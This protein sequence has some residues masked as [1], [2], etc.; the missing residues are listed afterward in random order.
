MK[1]RRKKHFVDSAVQG[2]L[3]RRIILHWLIF[4]GLA[5]LM[6]PLWQ[7]WASGNIFSPFSTLVAESWKN[8]APV[9]LALIALLPL[10]IW[11]TVTLTHRFAGPMRRF[12]GSIKSLAAGDKVDPIRLRKGDFWMEFAEDFN[13]LL[14]RL[15][16]ERRPGEE[17]DQEL[18]AC[19]ASTA[20]EPLDG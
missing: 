12:H 4:L 6:L 8:T 2:A 7:L 3:V 18:V 13:L 14:E 10:F 20:G 15:D 11:D 1:S 19:A 16:A 9:F 17:E 5:A